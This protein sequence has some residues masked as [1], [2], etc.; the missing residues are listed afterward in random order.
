M[1][2][3]PYLTSNLDSSS[4]TSPRRT[5][6]APALNS[7]ARSSLSDLPHPSY[8]LSMDYGPQ[9]DEHG[10]DQSFSGTN[11]SKRGGSILSVSRGGAPPAR[12]GR[13][14]ARAL[15]IAFNSPHLGRS[16][17][18]DAVGEAFNDEAYS[19]ALRPDEEDD[20]DDDGDEIDMLEM[21][22]LSTSQGSQ[23]DNNNVTHASDQRE[24]YLRSRFQPLTYQEMS[25]MGVSALV[26]V[27]L[28]AAAVLL[29][30]IG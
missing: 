20:D 5:Q 10:G 9:D 12:T 11:N 2:S 14:R 29:A 27:A 4:S 7:S 26:V 17:G 19:Y 21:T 24:E 13:T 3:S 18:E 15:S 30:A 23:R 1:P 8:D 16:N 28:S 25:W 22:R 6:P